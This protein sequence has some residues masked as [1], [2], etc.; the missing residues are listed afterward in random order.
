MFGVVGPQDKDKMLPFVEY[1]MFVFDSESD[2]LRV[3]F[4][5]EATYTM[6]EYNDISSEGIEQLRNEI[7]RDRWKFVGQVNHLMV[8]SFYY[9]RYKEY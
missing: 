6:D 5:D 4:Y 3:V 9:Q 1:C 2:S 8:M 7:L